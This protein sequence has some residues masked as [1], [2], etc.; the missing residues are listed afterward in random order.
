V[1]I[2]AR[3]ITILQVF[4][5]IAIIALTVVTLFYPEVLGNEHSLQA[6][7]EKEAS[8]T[9][10]NGELRSTESIVQDAISNLERVQKDAESI[11]QDTE[12]LRNGIQNTNFELH[13]PSILVSLEQKAK[14]YELELLIEYDGIKLAETASQSNPGEENRPDRD[15][16]A[17]GMPEGGPPADTGAPTEGGAPT[18]DRAPIEGRPDAE[19]EPERDGL[20]QGGPDTT[21]PP[22]EKKEPTTEKEPEASAKAPAEKA[23]TEKAPETASG[24]EEPAPK[25][26]G[27]DSSTPDAIDTTIALQNI[28]SIPGVSVTIIPVRVNGTYANVRSFIQYLD[29]VDFMED[30]FV[31]LHSYGDKVSG[32]IVFNVFHAE[33]G[34]SY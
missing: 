17:E 11:K 15:M 30:N 25:T 4:G 29:E 19:R 10:L 21:L 28:P 34:G 27:K 7:E 5:I 1:K 23:S 24:K 31:D 6:L 3:D 33:G 32:I 16:P 12:R 2:T 22:E 20:G 8:V 13:M 18:D 14:E 9:S 26:T